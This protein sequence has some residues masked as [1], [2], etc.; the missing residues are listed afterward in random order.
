M[1]SI[2]MKKLTIIS[3]LLSLTI[4]GTVK[5]EPEKV[6]ADIVNDPAYSKYKEALDEYL[7]SPSGKKLMENVESENANDK[8]PSTTNKATES[9]T[10]ATDESQNH[11]ISYGGMSRENYNKTLEKIIKTM[12]TK[13]NKRIRS[14][15]S[16]YFYPEKN[17]PSGYYPQ[18][19]RISHFQPTKE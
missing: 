7:N 2:S 4:A 19:L 3:I 17:M 1:Y 5:S 8:K 15:S 11:L 6:P 12:A 14:D 13:N 16:V 10:N 18:V 9:E